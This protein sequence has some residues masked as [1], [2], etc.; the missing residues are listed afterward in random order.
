M[1]N[2]RGALGQGLR[3]WLVAMAAGLALASVDC[4]E[5]ERSGAPGPSGSGGSVGTGG[6][7][8]ATVTG[9]GGSSTD[10]GGTGVDAGAGGA[11]GTGGVGGGVDASGR[12]GSGGSPV[13]GSGGAAGTPGSWTGKDNVPSSPNPPGGLAVAR[14]P[15]F[16]ALGFDDNGYSG[17]NPS[18]PGG[19][20]WALD[21][22]RPLRN[23]PGTGKAATYDG[24]PVRLTFYLTSS[25]AATTGG[26][27]GLV[28]RAWRTALDD[29]HEI[30]NHTHAHAHGKPFTPE[31]WREEITTCNDW[32]AKPYDPAEPNG[33]NA[34]KGIGLPA[35]EMFGFRSPFL[36]HNDALFEPL[37]SLGFWYD[38]S[39][40]DGWQAEQNG[41]NYT[42][43]YTLDSGS[44]GNDLLARRGSK[45]PITAHP[46]LWE[47]SV[48]PVV[49][50]PDERAVEYGIAP[51]LRAKLKTVVTWFE[52]GNGKITGFDYNLWVDFKL[53]KAEFLAVMKHTLDLRLAG[54]RAPFMLGAH[55]D[56]YAG[57]YTASMNATVRE[58]QEAIEEFLRYALSK[59]QVRV[60]SVK[61]ILDW[62]RNPVAL[63]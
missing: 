4:A 19:V 8:G 3:G 11:A 13:T 2:R 23:P 35:G 16:V 7:G 15:Q 50:P 52:V 17:L 1:T 25:Y 6:S 9:A 21:T 44:A 37:K 51:G 40:E 46:G 36:E 34:A 27:A 30:G 18:Q 42:W 56:I 14:V 54:N 59:P 38:C 22:V 29:K 53:T 28:K 45:A 43:P 12:A 47:M 39:L 33:G 55:T 5:Q 60:S 32:L 31:K 49:V 10:D 62:V 58:R 26:D 63:D 48:H 41:T 57:P 24:A 61:Q 20:K